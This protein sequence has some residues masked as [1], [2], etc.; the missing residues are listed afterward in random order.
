MAKRELCNEVPI[1][2]SLVA[3]VFELSL[4]NDLENL[5]H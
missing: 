3:K 1:V 5:S 2:L 4:S